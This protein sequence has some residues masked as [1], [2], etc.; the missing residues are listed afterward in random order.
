MEI[1]RFAP[2]PSGLMH[3]G[4][5]YAAWFARTKA[6]NDGRFLLR[7]EDLDTTRCRPEFEEE[8]YRDLTWLG[9]A[10]NVPVMRQSDRSSAYASALEVLA[11]EGLLYPCFC[12]RRA[13]HEEIQRAV[14]AP[15]G[16]EGP[17]YPG[18]CRALSHTEREEKLAA[19]ESH[20]WRLDVAAAKARVGDLRWHDGSR[21]WIKAAPENLGD[22]VLARKDAPA[23]YHLAV[24]VD[25]AA[26]G[27]TLVTRG[28][29]LFEATHIHRLLQE[30]LRLP[31]PAWHHH[32]L[33]V[34]ESGRRLAKRD[35]ARALATLREAGAKPADIISGF[36]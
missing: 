13:I 14:S 18:T 25:D 9:L 20:A 6:G 34:D 31:V 1:T 10:W 30:I 17:L 15:H 16:P 32:K 33:I 24:V 4:H 19:N 3:L 36:S 35:H 5:A 21:G 29:D 27:I 2:S 12:T 11:G 8:I 28:E 7:L 26:Q 22:V 23:A